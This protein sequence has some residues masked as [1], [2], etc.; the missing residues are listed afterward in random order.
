[1][2]AIILQQIVHMLFSSFYEQEKYI[3]YNYIISIHESIVLDTDH[4]QT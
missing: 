2:L 3:L 4:V 1:M